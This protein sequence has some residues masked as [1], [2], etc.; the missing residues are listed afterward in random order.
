MSDLRFNASDLR[1]NVSYLVGNVSD[2]WFNSLDWDGIVSDK[3][4]KPIVGNSK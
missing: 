2:L 3:I 4:L 1:F